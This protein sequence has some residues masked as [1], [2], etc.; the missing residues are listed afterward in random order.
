MTV[1]ADAGRIGATRKAC[2]NSPDFEV[3]SFYRQEM[4]N[5]GRHWGRS[6]G[7]F[8]PFSLSKKETHMKR[9]LMVLAAV[10]ALSAAGESQGAV[11]HYRSN[12]RQASPAPVY[13]NTYSYPANYG[14]RSYNSGRR[15]G[16]F[17]QMMELE[18]RKNAALRRMFGGF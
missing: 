18:R 11:I 3:E 12:Y 13:R 16:I 2:V 14:Y 4:P 10:V 17:A 1:A 6:S 15:R 8:C 5:D 9:L 7:G